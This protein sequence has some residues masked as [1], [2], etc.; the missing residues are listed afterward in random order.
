MNIKKSHWLSACLSVLFLLAACSGNEATTDF[1]D[2]INDMPDLAGKKVSVISG[3]MHDLVLADYRPEPTVLRLSSVAEVIASVSSGQADYALEDQSALLGMNLSEYGLKVLFSSDVVA[4]PYGFA[5][6]PSDVGLVREFNDFLSGIRA[7][8]RYDEIFGRWSTGDINSVRMPDIPMNPDGETIR[9]GSINIF[10][11]NFIQDGKHAGFEVEL[12]QTFAAETGRNVQI[13]F[14][15]FSGLIA[16][17]VTGKI[18]MIAST[19]TIT[20]E[21]SKQVQFSDPYYDCNTICLIRDLEAEASTV[22]FVDKV[23][24]SFYNN[25]ILEDRWQIVLKGLYETLIISLIS[26]L[27]GS[28]FGAFVCWMRMSRKKVLKGIAKTY[29]EIVRGV[30]ILVLLMLMFYVV[31]AKGGI[32]ARWVAIIAFALNFGAYVSEMYRTGIESI[33]RGQTE[34]GLAMGFSPFKTFIF[35]VVP[36]AAKKVLPVFKGEAVSLFKN[37]SVVG[38]IAIQD[39]T[40]ASE[41]IRARTFDAFFPLIIISILYFTLAWLFGKLLDKLGNKL[42]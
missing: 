16:A 25:L 41:I 32:T 6:R 29:I 8:G 10:P 33:E 42:A 12:I 17:L 4:G 3:S 15:D 38:F 34:A 28:I 2:G 24:D 22:S 1:A 37:T 9:V 14:I 11:F 23:K 30:P 31:F 20:E 39:L 35:F 27:L 19:M 21:R 5:F 7:D 36:Q 13:D 40:K 26:I 18:D